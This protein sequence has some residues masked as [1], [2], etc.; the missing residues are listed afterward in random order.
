M[1]LVIQNCA[2]EWLKLLISCYV[3][4]TTVQLFEKR[5]PSEVCTHEFKASPVSIVEYFSL[6]LPG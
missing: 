3:Y 6:A 1:Y 5:N 2:F 4:F